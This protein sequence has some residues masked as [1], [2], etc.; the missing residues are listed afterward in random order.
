MAPGPAPRALALLACVIALAHPAPGMAAEPEARPAIAITDV[1]VVD[2]AHGRSHGPRT[3][4][5][6]AGRIVAIGAPGRVAIPGGAQRV[7]G[8]G[9]Y[10]VPGLVDMH[11]HLFNNAS[12]RPPNDWTFPMFVAHGVTA[13][14]EMA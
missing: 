13:V 10:L 8:R 1:T 14:R 3:V 4:L 5:I 7:D 11:V 2:V 12:H 6:E 9:R